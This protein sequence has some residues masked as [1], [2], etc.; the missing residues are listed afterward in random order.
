VQHTSVRLFVFFSG[1]LFL[2]TG[3]AKLISANGTARI[4]NDLDPI[5][6]VSFRHILY[7]AGVAELIVSAICFFS[8]NRELQA[9]SVAFLA[10]IFL[11]YRVGLYW[12]GFHSVCP[13]LGNI[14]DAL[15]IRSQTADNI[16]KIVLAYFVIG[17]YST[18]FCLW[19]QTRIPSSS[20]LIS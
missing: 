4:L 3:A 19:K 6:L 9:C 5:F 8:R 17:S 7:V 12:D 13:C 14:S 11:L 20:S 15:H 18:M 2:L 10:T 1:F 16:M